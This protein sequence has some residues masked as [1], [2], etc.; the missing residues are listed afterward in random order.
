MPVEFCLAGPASVR[1]LEGKGGGARMTGAA[2]EGG[3]EPER[4]S[5]AEKLQRLLDARTPK[6]GKRPSYDSIA[7]AINVSGGSISGPYIWQL[8][9]GKADNPKLA[10]LRDLARYFGV[11]VAYLVD[12]EAEDSIT[13]QLEA[14]RALKEEG[15]LG[16]DIQAKDLS[17]EAI[18]TLTDMVRFLKNQENNHPR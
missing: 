8:V 11:P 12:D 2:E 7:R 6:G 18:R 10:H 5:L 1:D 16:L 14:L 15:V 13:A 4:R 3:Q 9:T 17:L